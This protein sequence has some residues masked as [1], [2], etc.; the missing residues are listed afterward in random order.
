MMREEGLDKKGKQ[1]TGSGL[2]MQDNLGK[3]P[4]NQTGP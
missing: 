2:T 1:R 4:K 3:R